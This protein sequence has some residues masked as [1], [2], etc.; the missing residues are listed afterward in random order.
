MLDAART[1]GRQIQHFARAGNSARQA[2]E[3]FETL[4]SKGEVWQQT[5]QV[6]SCQLLHHDLNS[7]PIPNCFTV[8]YEQEEATRKLRSLLHYLRNSPVRIPT[9]Q[10]H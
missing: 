1:A 9:H 7:A 10:A 8:V 2:K 3:A 5:R 6:G 4:E